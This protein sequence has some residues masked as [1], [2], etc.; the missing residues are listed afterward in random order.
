MSMHLGHDTGKNMK[1][2]NGDEYSGLGFCTQANLVIE[3][4]D[5]RALNV[6]PEVLKTDFQCAEITEVLYADESNPQ[7]NMN[8]NEKLGTGTSNVFDEELLNIVNKILQADLEA[9]VSLKWQDMNDECFGARIYGNAPLADLNTPTLLNFKNWDG[10]I[11]DKDDEFYLDEITDLQQQF[12]QS[13]IKI[14]TDLAEDKDLETYENVIDVIRENPLPSPDID[15]HYKGS[16][17]CSGTDYGNADEETVEWIIDT[18]QTATLN[19]LNIGVVQPIGKGSFIT[20][21]LQELAPDPD[22]DGVVYGFSAY[23][24][25]LSSNLDLIIVIYSEG[26]MNEERYVSYDSLRFNLIDPKTQ[27]RGISSELYAELKNEF[28]NK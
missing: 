25:T 7:V 15:I 24:L 22:S 16:E 9:I 4:A 11:L 1:E 28:L 19:L 20:L 5:T 26:E 14:F 17:Q 13:R 3:K 23:K 18:I 2:I 8:I 6:I 27:D 12:L 21:I 10:D